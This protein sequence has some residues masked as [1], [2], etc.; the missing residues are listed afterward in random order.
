MGG[1]PWGD[2]PAPRAVNAGR[3]EDRV[4]SRS[5]Y[6]DSA[7]LSTLDTSCLCRVQS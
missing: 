2:G 4:S 5:L 1:C 6:W 7:G 3:R